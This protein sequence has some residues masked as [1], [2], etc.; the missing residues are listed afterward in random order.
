MTP[1]AAEFCTLPFVNLKIFQGL[2]F[3]PNTQAGF[4]A[5]PVTFNAF[6][7]LDLEISLK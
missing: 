6:V 5:D 4:D 1:N 7:A 2:Q 3:P